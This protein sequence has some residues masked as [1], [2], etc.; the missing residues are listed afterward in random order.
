MLRITGCKGDAMYGHARPAQPACPSAKPL[1]ALPH[2]DD[3]QNA[4]PSLEL[5]KERANARN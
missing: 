2:A 1:H 4:N 5:P 3:Q